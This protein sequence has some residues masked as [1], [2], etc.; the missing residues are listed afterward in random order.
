[1]FSVVS[2][3]LSVCL[4][5]CQFVRITSERLNVGQSNLAV[6]YIVKNLAQVQRSRSPGTKNEKLP[7]HPH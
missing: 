7:S 2:V 1:M 6:R 4:F 3:G 5:V